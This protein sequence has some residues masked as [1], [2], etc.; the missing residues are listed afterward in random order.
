MPQVPLANTPAAILAS[1]KV[2]PIT[3]DNDNKRADLEAFVPNFAQSTAWAEQTA[4]YGVGPL[5]MATPQHVAGNAPANMTDDNL[6]QLL[7]ANLTGANPAWGAPD[8]STIYAFFIPD[9]TTYNDFTNSQCCVDYDG[10][11]SVSTVGGVDLVY[12]VMCHCPGIDGPNINAL[13][14]LTVVASHEIVEAAT[15]PYYNKPAYA[16]SDDNHAVWTVV[17]GGEVGDMCAFA[18]N[19][20]WNPPDMQYMIQRSWSNQA[21]AA[22]HDPCVGEGMSPY[23]QTVPK[24][25]DS[26]TIQSYGWPTK[27]IH[28]ANGGTANLTLDVLSDT[29]GGQY[30]VELLD[31]NDYWTGGTKYLTFSAPPATV[32]VGDEFTVSVSVQ[33]KDPMI[34][35]G[36]VFI[37]A[38]T[39]VG[40]GMTTYYFGL[41][42]E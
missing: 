39:P 29:A 2:M 42:G 34:G 31:Y 10:Y 33:G 25:T 32:T 40:G 12:A 13:Q 20:Y 17:T 15:D 5:T 11:H 24:L 28:I 23:Y 1:P 36:A 41:V 37:V 3:Y 7:Q 38:T 30:K 9:G 8:P 22:G 14:Q 18:D 6:M 4:E 26:V 19:A 35:N 21:A 27:G 16:N